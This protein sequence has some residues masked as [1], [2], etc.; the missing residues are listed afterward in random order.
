MSSNT[1]PLGTQ[2]GDFAA[3]ERTEAVTLEEVREEGLEGD[4]AAGERTLPL[5]PHERSEESLHGDFAGGERT[6]P[7]TPGEEVPGTFADT[8][9]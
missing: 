2:T 1:P 6:E 8:S 7:L 5:T 9:A 4:F 3:G